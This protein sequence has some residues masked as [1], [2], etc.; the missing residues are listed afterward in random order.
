MTPANWFWATL[1]TALLA[2]FIFGASLSAAA[3]GST[4][5]PVHRKQVL[6]IHAVDTEVESPVFE[7]EDDWT[8][9]CAMEGAG[10]DF[11]VQVFANPVAGG[12]SLEVIDHA[13]AGT[14]TMTVRNGG[15][16]RLKVVG[17]SAD[18]TVIVENKN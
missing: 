18:F 14:V 12:S 3:S 16:Y 15:R 17:Y 5:A 2:S 9:T 4:P 1:G 8:V 7:V 11:S 13:Q 10:P 6:R